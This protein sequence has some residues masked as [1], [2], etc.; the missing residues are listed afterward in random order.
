MDVTLTHYLSLSC[1]IFA[2]GI[3]GLLIACRSLISVLM[4]LELLLLGVNIGFVA[5]SAFHQNLVG[6]ITSLFV[7]AVAAAEAAIGLA[8]VIV[9]YRQKQT[10]SLMSLSLLKCDLDDTTDES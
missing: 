9:Y 8:I 1:M 4:S 5:C 2:V 3:V 6:Q 10:I 7:L